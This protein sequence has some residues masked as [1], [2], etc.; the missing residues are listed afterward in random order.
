[1]IDENTGDL[2]I[3][4]LEAFVPRG[5][6]SPG[7]DVFRAEVTSEGLCPV[8][9]CWK[10]NCITSIQSI[11]NRPESSLKLLLPRFIE[12]HAH[13]DKAFTWQDFPNLEGTYEGALKANFQE[14]QTRTAE[15]VHF[16]AERSFKKALKNGLR[17]IRTHVDSSGPFAE[18]TWDTLVEL[19]RKWQK[20]IQLQF[21][22][23][24]PL[25]DWTSPAGEK[26]A[27]RVADVGGLL[28]GVLVPPIQGKQ[29]RQLLVQLFGLA[30]HLGC[31]VDL[32]IDESHR[33]PAAGLNQVINVLDELNFKISLTCSHLSSISLLKERR[34][35]VLAERLAEHEVNVVALPLTNSWLLGRR[36]RNTPL[37]R[38][39][40]PIKQLQKAGVTVAVGGDNVQDP[41]FPGGAF[42]P[43]S[44]MSFS[45]PIAQ[46]APWN[47]LGLAPFTTSCARIMG[48]EW[49]CTF[50]SGSPADFVCVEA[51]TWAEVLSSSPKRK[52]VLNGKYLDESN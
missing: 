23:M 8:R 45:M 5:L 20:L 29:S 47:R 44:L 49:D 28:G 35:R 26:F 46:L 25:E 48:L 39:M 38:P 31:G 27:R 1:M 40:A 6:I 34:L 2:D 50:G 18:Q 32:H 15:R 21:V 22:A 9:I 42:D 19:R 16:R 3:S 7:I 4:S 52:V 11:H 30:N 24:A 43:L 13:V 37:Q 10:D 33:F 36:E 51:Q 12:P 41:W 17:A 14:H